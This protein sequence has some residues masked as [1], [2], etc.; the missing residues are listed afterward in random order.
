MTRS[1]GA[2][3]EPEIDEPPPNGMM[4]AS[5][6]SAACTVALTSSW[7]AGRTITS[8]KTGQ[9]AVPLPDQVAQRLSARVDD[10]IERIARDEAFADRLLEFGRSSAGRFGS[11]M[12]S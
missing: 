4:T 11:G 10:A 5:A 3:S 8:G 1:V 7:L 6:R 2:S 9:L 12:R